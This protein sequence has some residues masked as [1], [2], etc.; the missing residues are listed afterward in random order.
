MKVIA[1]RRKMNKSHRLGC[2]AVAT[3]LLWGSAAGAVSADAEITECD[4]LV[5][6]PRDP[7]RVTTGVPSAE[8]DVAAGIAACQAAVEADPDGARA[9]YQLGRVYFYDDRVDKA[10]SHLEIAAAA[11]HRQT[12]FVLG[13][14][15][16]TGLKGVDQDTCRAEELWA[17]SARAGRLAALVSYPHHVVRGRFDACT[18]QVSDAEMMDFLEQAETFDL[19]YYQ[20]VLVGDVTED[21]AAYIASR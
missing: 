18:L 20:R 15:L 1:R 2:A 4:R 9:N 5:S 7:D 12:M 3:L 13:Y 14:I 16:D 10:M 11:N 17:R 21:L 19:D 6:H 8:V